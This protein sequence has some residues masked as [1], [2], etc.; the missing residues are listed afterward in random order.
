MT[1]AAGVMGNDRPIVATREF[2]YCPRLGFNLLSTVDDPQTGKQ[3]F[4]VKDFSTSEPDPSFFQ[5][6]AG[7]KFVDHMNGTN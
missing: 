2:W 3:V 1:I 4:T 6:P 7:Y 5:P